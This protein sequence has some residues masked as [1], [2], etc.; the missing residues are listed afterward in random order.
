MQTAR[1]S[2]RA[3]GDGHHFQTRILEAR[4]R[5]HHMLGHHAVGGQRVVDIGQHA[6]QLWG[7]AVQTKGAEI[8]GSQK[9]S[10]LILA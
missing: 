4:N 6:Q 9:L 7:P 2:P 3:A 8:L 5:G 1:S 10:M